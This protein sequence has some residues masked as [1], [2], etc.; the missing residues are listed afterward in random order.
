LTFQRVETFTLFSTFVHYQYGY[1]YTAFLEAMGE[2]SG[3]PADHATMSVLHFNLVMRMF[4]RHILHCK[5]AS[6]GCG[7]IVEYMKR[8][9]EQDILKCCH[10]HVMQ[11]SSALTPH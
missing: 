2:N 8:F 4:D 7:T 5:T 10:L 11:V 3:V 6:G 9:E 1:K